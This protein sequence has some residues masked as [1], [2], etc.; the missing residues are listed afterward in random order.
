M[1]TAV[2][3]CLLQGELHGYELAERIDQMV[4]AYV[5]VDPGSTYR[6][7]RELESEGY[8]ASAWHQAESGPSRR[9]YRVTDS[10]RELLAEWAT[11]LERRA[12]AMFELAQSARRVLSPAGDVMS[13]PDPCL[14][15]KLSDEK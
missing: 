6:L 15:P 2:L 9:N 12:S 8:L 3:T 7:L 11:F 5:C 13:Q 1:Q 10:G 14:G 4:G